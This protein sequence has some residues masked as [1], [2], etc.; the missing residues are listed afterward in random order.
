MGQYNA[1]LN[2]GRIEAEDFFKMQ[3]TAAAKM[4][5]GSGDDAFEVMGLNTGASLEFP[6]LSVG[7]S[8]ANITLVLS[9]GGSVTTGQVEVQDAETGVVYGTCDVPTSDAWD[10][11]LDLACGSLPSG[12]VNLVLSFGGA[13][14]SEV[15]AHLD[16]FYLS[17]T[18][19]WET[20]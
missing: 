15:F 3:G 16:Y 10:A 8:E 2:S 12:E 18:S 13:E 1:S 19:A 9:N 20:A 5:Q 11:Y 4:E 17:P 6:H 7:P 14:D